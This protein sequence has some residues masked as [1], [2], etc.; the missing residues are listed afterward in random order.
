MAT[1]PLFYTAN[2]EAT[3]TIKNSLEPLNVKLLQAA[4]VAAKV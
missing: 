4:M 1:V 3:V 2:L